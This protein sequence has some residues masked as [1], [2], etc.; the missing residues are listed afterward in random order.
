MERKVWKKIV[1]DDIII[2]YLIFKEINREQIIYYLGIQYKIP[3]TC[4][5]KN[6]NLIYY[7]VI[8][9]FK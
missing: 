2:Y 4:T 8:E 5:E 1:D 3:H 6:Y 7:C 9:N